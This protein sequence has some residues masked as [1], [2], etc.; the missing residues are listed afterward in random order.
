MA[1]SYTVEDR[2]YKTPCWIWQRGKHSGGYGLT[3]RHSYVHRLLYEERYGPVPD[4]RELDHLCRQA[5]CVN[6][7]HLEPVTHAENCRRGARSKITAA[8]AERIRCMAAEGYSYR[9]IERIF[10]LHNSSISRIVN[11]QRWVP[12]ASVTAS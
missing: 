2:G 3:G 12:D 6:P 5:S 9:Y 11:G 10:G 1:D 7:D 4:G 8:D